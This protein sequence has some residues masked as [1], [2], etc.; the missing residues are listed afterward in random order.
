MRYNVLKIVAKTKA[1]HN[2][3]TISNICDGSCY[4]ESIVVLVNSD[5]PCS[6]LPFMAHA[7]VDYSRYECDSGYYVDGTATTFT[8]SLE[9]LLTP[10]NQNNVNTPPVWSGTITQQCVRKCLLLSFYNDIYNF[11]GHDIEIHVF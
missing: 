10:N 3:Y 9:C 8:D 6:V 7:S 11:I 2:P 5:T 4:N 1:V